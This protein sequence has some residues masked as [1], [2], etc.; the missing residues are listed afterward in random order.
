MGRLGRA[1]LGVILTILQVIKIRIFSE[2]RAETDIWPGPHQ[3]SVCTGWYHHGQEDR[4]PGS[5]GQGNIDTS[6]ERESGS[7]Q[8]H[9]TPPDQNNLTLETLYTKAK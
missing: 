2:H 7:G 6:A 8:E 5:S 9:Q 3:W 4:A 1:Q